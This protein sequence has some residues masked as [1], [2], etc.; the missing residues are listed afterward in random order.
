[1]DEETIVSYNIHGR[2]TNISLD[3][4]A[5][6]LN[7]PYDILKEYYTLYNDVDTAVEKAREIAKK[8]E[9]TYKASI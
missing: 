2:K 9:D 3:L 8:R 1:M 7:I 4:L 6:S 5:K